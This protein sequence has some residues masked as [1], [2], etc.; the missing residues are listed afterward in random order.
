M[1][2]KRI[3]ISEVHDQQVIMLK[4]VEGDR[5]F[6]IV[7][8][9]FE[10]TSIDRR[11]KKMHSPRP[12]THDLVA[13]VIDQLGGDLQDIDRLERLEKDNRRQLDDRM[14]F[15]LAGE[16][17]RNMETAMN[18]AETQ[19]QA[20]GPSVNPLQVPR[21]YRRGFNPAGRDDLLGVQRALTYAGLTALVF[22]PAVW[23]AWAFLAR[24]GYSYVLAG[25]QGA[26]AALA[27][28]VEAT[29]FFAGEAT[30]AEE[31]GTV[32]GALRSGFRAAREIL[33]SRPK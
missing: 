22:W 1:E 4:E 9:I 11:V 20:A 15:S 14:K 17:L 33:R 32:A 29:L 16:P 2:L 19:R 28:P 10:A 26:R 8:G 27:R 21:V 12:L 30:D 7:I 13:N 31:A 24:G 5:S 25:G 3:I 6:P 23:V 18:Q